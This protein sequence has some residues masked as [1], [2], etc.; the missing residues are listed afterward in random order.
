MGDSEGRRKLGK[1]ETRRKFKINIYRREMGKRDVSSIRQ[2]PYGKWW[3]I[4][5]TVITLFG[6]HSCGEFIS[7][8]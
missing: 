8:M 4:V 6:F 5:N 7:C 2:A 3:D 1:S